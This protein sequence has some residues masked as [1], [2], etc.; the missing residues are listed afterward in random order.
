MTSTINLSLTTRL[1]NCI[2]VEHE[3]IERT[4]YSLALM[5]GTLTR[6]SYAFALAQMFNLHETLE[7]LAKQ[8]TLLNPF[9]LPEMY[10]ASVIARDL[11]RLGFELQQFA[12]LPETARMTEA[13]RKQ[14]VDCP[15]SMIGGLYVLEG[16]RMGSLVLAK[17]LSNCLGISGGP[18]SGIDYHVDGAREVPMRLKLWKKQVDDTVFDPHTTAAIERFAST[19]MKNLLQVYAAFPVA[20]AARN[21]A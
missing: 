19:L 4:P 21:I 1:R 13:L 14:F 15:L 7:I 18:D 9:F 16:S 6:R 12:V 5:Q 17:P 3:A 20:E 2:A 10:R 8:T 11:S